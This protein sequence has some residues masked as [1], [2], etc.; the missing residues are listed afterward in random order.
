MLNYL[1]V[2]FSRYSYLSTTILL[3]FNH[4][5]KVF[6]HKLNG[7]WA[8]NQQRKFFFTYSEVLLNLN[9]TDNILPS[10]GLYRYS[11][12]STTAINPNIKFV[13]FNLAKV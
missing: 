6:C 9:Y 12:M 5:Y 7:H 13:N 2:L 3:E 11:V 1:I 10:F 8:G 4:C